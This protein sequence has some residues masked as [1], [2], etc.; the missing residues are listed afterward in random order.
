MKIHYRE[1][2]NTAKNHLQCKQCFHPYK[3]L[4]Y[5]QL[6]SLINIAETSSCT[7]NK[8]YM[9]YHHHLC[10]KVDIFE[11][12]VLGAALQRFPKS[13]KTKCFTALQENNQVFKNN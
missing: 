11:S 6:G 12:L 5:I 2:L 8:Y 7:T 10:Y 3:R 13:S 4:L 1:T 9:V